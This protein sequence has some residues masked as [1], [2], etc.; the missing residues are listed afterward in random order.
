MTS[1]SDLEAL[2]AVGARLRAAG[3][4]PVARSRREPYA[5]EAV[6]D[7]LERLRSIAA[8]TSSPQ[9]A[10]THA[11]PV[12]RATLYEEYGLSPEQAAQVL[13]RVGT[14]IITLGDF[15]AALERMDPFERIRYQSDDRNCGDQVPRSALYTPMA[16]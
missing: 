3:A 14:R 6:S 4:E 7:G 13:A 5:L 15:A 1:R 9:A 10:G 16:G 12:D 2:R 11:A 8:G